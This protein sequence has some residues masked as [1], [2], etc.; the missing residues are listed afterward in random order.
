MFHMIYEKLDTLK[1]NSIDMKLIFHIFLRRHIK[2]NSSTTHANVRALLIIKATFYWPYAFLHIFVP[3]TRMI[4]ARTGGSVSSEG[5]L[6]G[7]HFRYAS[8]KSN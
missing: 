5:I 4:L 7:I 6:I 1:K 2:L 3:F 8:S